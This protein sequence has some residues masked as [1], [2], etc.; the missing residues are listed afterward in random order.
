MAV[1]IRRIRRWSALATALVLVSLLLTACGGGSSDNSSTSSASDGSSASGGGSTTQS[2]TPSGDTGSGGGGGTTLGVSATE[3]GGLGFS[4]R[5]LTARAG[6][7]TI[8][9]SNGSEDA[10]PHA[11]AIE[12]NGVDKDGQTVQP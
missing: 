11:I 4:K 8:R 5:T 3:R 1:S 2:Q 12:G 6:T 7:V 9:L 10:L